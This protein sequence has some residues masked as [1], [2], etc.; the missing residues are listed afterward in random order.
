MN[1]ENLKELN[2]SDPKTYATL[3]GLKKKLEA[4]SLHLANPLIVKLDGGR[5]TAIFNHQLCYEHLH[6][7]LAAAFHGFTTI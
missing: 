6:S 1:I 3:N 5:Y 2:A 7:S 4:E